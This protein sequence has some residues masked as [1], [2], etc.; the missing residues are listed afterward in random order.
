[1][2]PLLVLCC[3]DGP[4]QL[5]GVASRAGLTHAAVLS[6]L[7]DHTHMIITVLLLTSDFK[8][9]KRVELTTTV[10]TTHS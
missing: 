6:P 4:P 7:H 1:M 2:M 10:I 8:V 5:W 9:P 3:L